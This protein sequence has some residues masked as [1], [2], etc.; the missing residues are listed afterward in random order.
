[1]IFIGEGQR[2]SRKVEGDAWVGPTMDDNQ[3]TER[4]TA[5]RLWLLQRLQLPVSFVLYLFPRK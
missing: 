2:G 5:G 4:I 1:M 3:D